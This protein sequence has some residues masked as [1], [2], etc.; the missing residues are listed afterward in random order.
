M[1][2]QFIG[3]SD[4]SLAVKTRVTQA[5]LTIAE[6]EQRQ[7]FKSEAGRGLVF[8]HSGRSIPNT[9]WK[10]TEQGADNTEILW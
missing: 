7:V 4:W 2:L 3:M 8:S 5:E 10:N 6:L 1:F 9:V